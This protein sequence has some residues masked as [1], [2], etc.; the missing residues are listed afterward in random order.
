[1][2]KKIVILSGAGISKES[3]IDTFRDK[4]GAWAKF[5]PDEVASIDGWNKNPEKVLAFYNARRRQLLEV[6][7]NRAHELVAALEEWYDV[8]IITQNVDNLH[9]R[10]GSSNVIHL[11]GELSKVC[12][13]TDKEDPECI[14]FRPLDED[15]I[16][17]DKAKD[18]SQLRPYI[19]W[20]GEPV[21]NMYYA[22][23]AMM[24]VDIFIVIGTSLLVSPA[25]V[26]AVCSNAAKNIVIDPNDVNVPE[27]F[28][29]IKENATDGMEILYNSLVK[30]AED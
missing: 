27:G 29:H 18:G 10:A 25:N 22:A 23:N 15:I 5:N 20:F 9:E 11:H 4:D 26:L 19:V 1:M 13:S 24:E 28:F 7:P 14:E 3:G 2:K 16:I 30:L 21:P 12:S 17:G 6:E 8:T